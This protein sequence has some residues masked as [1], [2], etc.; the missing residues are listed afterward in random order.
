MYESTSEPG[1]KFGSAFRGKRFDSYHAGESVMEAADQKAEP[2]NLSGD[3]NAPADI[4]KAHGP[5][6]HV[7]YAHNHE[8]NMH[9]VSSMHEDGHNDVSSHGSAAEAYGHGKALAFEA[10]GEEQASDVKK[11]EHPD[12][13]GAESEERNYEMPDLA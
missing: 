10:G 7:T 13:Q 6:T 9:T 2:K 1:R 12:Q 11:S 5:A 8:N 4:V 3:K